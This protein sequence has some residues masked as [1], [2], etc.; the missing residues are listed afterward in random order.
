MDINNKGIERII[1][2][3]IDFHLKVSIDSKIQLISIKITHCNDC[4]GVSPLFSVPKSWCPRI[5]GISFENSTKKE[6]KTSKERTQA[7]LD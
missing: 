4:D 7:K 5:L 1:I 3:W 2:S 6:K